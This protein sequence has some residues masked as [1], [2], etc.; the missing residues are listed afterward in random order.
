MT[1]AA[2]SNSSLKAGLNGLKRYLMWVGLFSL[3]I[4][5]LT[6]SIPLYS[7]QLFDRVLSSGSGATL[8]VLTIAVLGGLAAAALLEDVRTR[9]LVAL[10]IQFDSELATKVLERQIETG[11][12]G[13]ARAQVIRDLDHVR[14]LLTGSGTIALLDL[15]WA[16]IF[17]GVCFFL[18]PTLGTIT[19]GGVAMVL[20]LAVL[21]Q[22]LVT[23]PLHLSG[24]KAEESYRVADCALQNAETVRAL[25][26]LPDIV[27]RWS[28]IRHDA[29]YS[30]ADASTRNASVSSFIKFLRYA[31]QVTIMGTGAWLAATRE[32][33]SGA[34]FAASLIST[35]AL[36]PVDQIVAVWRQLVA[37]WE[38]LGRVDEVLSVPTAVASITLPTP[39]GRLVVENLSYVVPGAKNPTLSKV[40]FS[41]EPGDAV[42]IVGPSAAGKSTLAR[43]II[44]AVK[45]SEGT[46]RLDGAETWSWNRAEFGSHA[47]YVSQNIELFEGTI[48]ENIARF[49]AIGSA[50]IIDAAKLAGVH[51]M[52]L[53]LPHGY[54]TQLLA[55]GAPLSGGQRQRIAIARAVLGSPRLVV[56]DEPN[57]NLDGEGE[58]SLQSLLGT[59]K[60]RG[61]T[62]VMIAHRPSVLVTLDKVLVL[63]GGTVSEFGT[64]DTIMPRIAPG[65]PLAKTRIV[66]RA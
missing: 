28:I 27:R 65:F 22:R 4:N 31:L 59:L 64:I 36:M 3:G 8:A 2:T 60:S 26:M 21:N 58:A 33:S 56:F 40:N 29:I 66:G 34:L 9:L 52:I 16:P 17:I 45:P 55:N 63:R 19:L 35:R 12:A 24:R 30:Q 51:E 20:G 41:L 62:V 46:I 54:G 43:L 5:V 7:I 32:I 25:G 39:A 14:Q 57:S 38:A 11:E 42:G 18:H 1:V 49:K 15:P 23:G 13:A 37:G 6:L 61:V 53:A 48:A 47:G 10:G 50:A 44:G